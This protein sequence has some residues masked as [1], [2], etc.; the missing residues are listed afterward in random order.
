MKKLYSSQTLRKN[1]S[2][3]WTLNS[4]CNWKVDKWWLEKHLEKVT[5][6]KMSFLSIHPKFDFFSN[7][8]P[9]FCTMSF[10]LLFFLFW[11]LPKNI[12]IGGIYS[13]EGTIHEMWWGIYNLLQ[14]HWTV[15]FYVI[16]S[17]N[18]FV[19]LLKNQT[20]VYF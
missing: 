16:L 11:S 14:Y 8:F 19:K 17:F 4:K 9:P 6:E 3:Y 20:R 15:M 13:N 5:L 10:I 2:I 18:Y 12:S 7:T 1:K